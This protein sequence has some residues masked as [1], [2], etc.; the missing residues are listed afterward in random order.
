MF[1]SPPALMKRGDIGSA[2]HPIPEIAQLPQGACF[3]RVTN[4]SYHRGFRRTDPQ[5][6]ESFPNMGNSL[7]EQTQAPTANASD[8]TRGNFMPATLECSKLYFITSV[9]MTNLAMAES[10][11]L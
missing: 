11:M 5:W 3:A 7:S 2:A 8:G 4:R 10:P 9:A 1:E 6:K